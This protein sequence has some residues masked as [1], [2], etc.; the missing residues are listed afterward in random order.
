M[1]SRQSSTV[2]ERRE[3]RAAKIDYLRGLCESPDASDPGI[4]RIAL[5]RFGA[6]FS[7]RNQ[8][9]IIMQRPTATRVAGFHAW[10]ALGR[11]VRKGAKGIAIMIPLTRK[12]EADEGEAPAKGVRFGT[13]YVFD[14]GDTEPAA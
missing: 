2:A 13:G 3:A 6:D 11:Q 7:P 1:S 4:Q 8:M 12:A 9:L 5:E 10:R 14:I